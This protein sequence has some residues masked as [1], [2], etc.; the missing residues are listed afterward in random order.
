M[1]KRGSQKRKLKTKPLF[2]DWNP[3]SLSISSGSLVGSFRTNRSKQDEEVASVAGEPITREQ[4]M[5][6]ME[7]EVGRETLLDLVNEKVMEVA[8]EQYGIDVSDK[9]IDLRNCAYPFCGWSFP[10]WSW[11]WKKCGKKSVPT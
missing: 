4:W 1:E 9:E 6:A 8:A 11:T 2:R 10:F 5:T 3:F 7:K